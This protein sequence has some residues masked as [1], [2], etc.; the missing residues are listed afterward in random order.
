MGH[1]LFAWELGENLGH[2][3]RDL[4]IATRL[5][6]A[7]HRVTC[8]AANL[9]IAAGIF[10]KSDIPF[11]QAPILRQSPRA[12]NRSVSHAEIAMAAGYSD[13]N[14]LR[15]LVGGWHGLIGMARPDVLVADYAPTAIV[16]ARI[17]RTPVVLIGNGF[18]IPPRVKPLPPFPSLGSVTDARLI[19]SEE[20]V[21]NNVNEI[22][23]EWNTQPLPCFA[24]CFYSERR[25]LTTFAELDHF[26]M[27]PSEEYVGPI[28]DV[29]QAR[30]VQW[31][32]D[33]GQKRIFAYLRQ[34]MP[35]IQDLLAALRASEADIICSSPDLPDE[36]VRRFS[37]SRLRIFR[38]AVALSPLLGSADLVI[39]YGAGTVAASLLSGVPL[40]LIPR[41][42][43]QHLTAIRAEVTGAALVSRS[44]GPP[45]SYPALIQRLLC[46]EK[47]REAA[48]QFAERHASFSHE[49]AVSHVA[50]T[51]VETM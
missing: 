38:D 13:T 10:A 11:V 44:H 15:G 36:L 34:W 35:R 22:L 37:S 8:V 41:W 42:A 29:P 45:S 16:S 17:T 32:K 48:Q 51:I 14:S 46:D 50:S 23:A 6:Q 40:L 20:L 7:G 25:L 26:G 49:N 43:E 47:Y 33:T 39:A 24:D 31:N 21:L 19:H 18:E 3:S 30:A 12:P 5:K 27:R 9:R 28:F 2:L 1:V 4:P